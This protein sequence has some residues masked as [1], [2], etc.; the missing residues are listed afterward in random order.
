MNNIEFWYHH[1]G[2]SV[3]DIEAAITW[4]REILGFT[5]Q[6]RNFLPPAR[7]KVA[8]LQNGDLRVELFEV[9]NG[10]PLPPERRIPDQDLQTHGNKH[11]CFA[12]DNIPR[13]AELLQQRGAD[14]VWVKDH[15]NGRANMFIRD[16]AGNL[17]EFMQ[18]SRPEQLTAVI[19]I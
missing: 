4:Y 17:I 1:V 19:S 8:F 5:L 7:A 11:V 9:E 12:V 13:C 6:H 2:I 18:S 15:G 3:P 16:L 10:Q 14:I